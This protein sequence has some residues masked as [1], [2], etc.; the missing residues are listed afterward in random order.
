M[1][2]KNIER[3]GSQMSPD[4]NGEDVSAETA[5]MP[6][7]DDT[8]AV[9]VTQRLRDAEALAAQNLEGWQRIQAEFQNYRKRIERDSEAAHASMKAG[10]IRSFLPVLD[11]LQRALNNRPSDSGPWVG[12]I[13][14]I[15][16]KLQ[17]ILDSEGVRRIEAEGMLFDPNL[18]EAIS[19]EEA[20]G[21]ESGH[22]IAVTQ[23]GYMLGEL[24]VRPALV[25]VAK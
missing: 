5:G 6:A 11:D 16:R 15:H 10:I 24:V 25:R 23:N 1:S 3:N 8:Q 22:V 12:G 7:S 4:P 20:E 21:V 13:E 14:L 17:S 19:H 18:H 2:E 9:E